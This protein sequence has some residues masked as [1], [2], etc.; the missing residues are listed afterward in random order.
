MT[1]LTETLVD[2][3]MSIRADR[4][5]PAAHQA[6]RRMILDTNE[7]QIRADKEVSNLAQRSAVVFEFDPVPEACDSLPDWPGWTR[8]KM[9]LRVILRDGTVIRRDARPADALSAGPGS[10]RDYAGK[11]HDCIT[12]VPRL[13]Q[14]NV[15][16]LKQAIANLAQGGSVN[17]LLTAVRAS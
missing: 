12:S 7:Q 5:A 8:R 3:A 2:I 17:E 16:H 4:I 10:D 11:A 13:K 6:A 14:A 9:G 15:E 1:E